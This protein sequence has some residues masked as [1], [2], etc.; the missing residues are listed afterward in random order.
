VFDG[1]SWLAQDIRISQAGR[2][3]TNAAPALA[4]YNGQVYLAYKSGSNSVF[5]GATWLAQDIKITTNGKVQTGRGPA[6]ATASP[7]LVMVYRD[8][9]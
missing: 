2:T 7:Y 8:N 9:S 5:D 6:L 4:E 1:M 3:K